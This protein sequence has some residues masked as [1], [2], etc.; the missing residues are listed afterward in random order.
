MEF[1]HQ[2]HHTW[3]KVTNMS[4]PL[5]VD[6]DLA[7]RLIYASQVGMISQGMI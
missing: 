1:Y 3:Q 6:A 5:C 4:M 2:A 7:M